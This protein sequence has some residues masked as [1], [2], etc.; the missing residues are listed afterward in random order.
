MDFVE[1]FREF[2]NSPGVVL[3]ATACGLSV[4]FEVTSSRE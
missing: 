3:L 1:F 2:A 4:Y